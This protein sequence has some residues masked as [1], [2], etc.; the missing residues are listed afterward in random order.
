MIDRSL[1]NKICYNN[2]NVF[3]VEENSK[4]YFKY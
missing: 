2:L 1:K 3:E 4:Y